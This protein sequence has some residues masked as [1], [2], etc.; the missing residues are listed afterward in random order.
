MDKIL[1]LVNMYI[2]NLTE[3][4][5]ESQS[6]IAKE[7]GRLQEKRMCLSRMESIKSDIEEEMEKEWAMQKSDLVNLMEKGELCEIYTDPDRLDIF[8]VGYIVS[9]DEDFYILKSVNEYGK[10]DGYYCEIIDN[11]IK[12]EIK[13]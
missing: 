9:V 5:K 11:I 7:E 6:K 3:E 13:T 1:N 4:I 12:I 2:E 10:F 8:S